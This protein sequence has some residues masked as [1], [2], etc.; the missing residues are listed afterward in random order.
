M[1]RIF[2]GV[3]QATSAREPPRIRCAQTSASISV[4]TVN[5][6][7][8]SEIEFGRSRT[9]EGSSGGRKKGVV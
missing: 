6:S 9:G 7:L 1:M 2:C 4:N 8:Q 3:G 5:F